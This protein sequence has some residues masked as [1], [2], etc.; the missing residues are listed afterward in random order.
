MVEIGFEIPLVDWG[1]RKGQVKVAESNRK[2]VES[3]VRQET[4]NFRQNLFILV[5]RYGNQLR[6]LQTAVAPMR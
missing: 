3:Q 6:Q 5:E 2:L 1:R 4:Q